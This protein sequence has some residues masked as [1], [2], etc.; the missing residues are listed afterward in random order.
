MK[1]HENAKNVTTERNDLI[2][3]VMGWNNGAGSVRQSHSGDTLSVQYESSIYDEQCAADTGGSCVSTSSRYVW[4]AEAKRGA[5]RPPSETDSERTE[6]R[7]DPDRDTDVDPDDPWLKSLHQ[8]KI[9]QENESKQP[10]KRVIEGNSSI[11]PFQ[12]PHDVPLENIS[13]ARNGIWV[14]RCRCWWCAVS[15]NWMEKAI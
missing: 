3:K 9:A 4:N 2:N 15:T 7:F 11:Q 5:S 10:L 8:K 6:F 12:L 1:E 13:S 14:R